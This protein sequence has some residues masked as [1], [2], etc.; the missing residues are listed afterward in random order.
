MG[1][2]NTLMSGVRGKSLMCLRI[3]RD[4]GAFPSWL[5]SEVTQ[6]RCGL[7]TREEEEGDKVSIKRRYEMCHQ[8]REGG[9]G[10]W[11]NS[12]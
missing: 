3:E 5:E 10:W 8:R 6:A 12:R 11:V 2:K 7:C 9:E 1:G 4:E